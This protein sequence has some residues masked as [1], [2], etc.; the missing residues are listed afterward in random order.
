[1]PWLLSTL[2]TRGRDPSAILELWPAPE[3][4]LE[5]TIGKERAW[6]RQSVKYLRGVMG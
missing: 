6:A 1:V 3:A 4:T 5:A 2:A